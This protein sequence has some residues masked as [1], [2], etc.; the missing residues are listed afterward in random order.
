MNR[1]NWAVVPQ[2]PRLKAWSSLRVRYS[3]GRAEMTFY[4][5]T[6]HTKISEI[7]N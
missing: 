1:M 2:R 4:F 3:G 6:K 7:L 5:T